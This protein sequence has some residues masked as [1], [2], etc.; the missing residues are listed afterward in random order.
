LEEGPRI[1]SNIVGCKNEDIHMDMPLELTFEKVEEQDW[2]LPKFKPA[3]RSKSINK[4]K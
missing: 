1:H 4:S 2:Y 3:T